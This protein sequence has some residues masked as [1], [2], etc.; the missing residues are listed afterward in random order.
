[1]LNEI[2]NNPIVEVV[3]RMALMA[4][5]FVPLMIAVVQGVKKLAGLEGTAAQV[6]AIAINLVFGLSFAA[7]FF[8][9]E[10]AVYVGVVMFLL[11]L[12]VAPL[13]GYDLLKIFTREGKGE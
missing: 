2:V 6:T 1:M 7:V 13:G 5:V 11:M 10:A 9:P 3:E 8:Y 12:A 4:A